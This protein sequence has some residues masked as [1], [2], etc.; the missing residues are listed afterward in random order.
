MDAYTAVMLVAIFASSVV[1]AF[2]AVKDSVPLAVV[3]LVLAAAW[4]LMMGGW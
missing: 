1:S 4:V 2:A 3:A